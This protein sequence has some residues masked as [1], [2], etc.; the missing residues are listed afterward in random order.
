MLKSGFSGSLFANVTP[1]AV[2][3]EQLEQWRWSVGGAIAAEE[4]SAA[5]ERATPLAGTGP[6]PPPAFPPSRLFRRREPYR[7]ASARSEHDT[8]IGLRIDVLLRDRDRQRIVDQLAPGP[9]A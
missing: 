9:S 7:L 6:H 4:G 1:V 8:Q 2:G 3:R 5:N